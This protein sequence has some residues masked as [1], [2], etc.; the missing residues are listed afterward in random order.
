MW[1]DLDQQA[2]GSNCYCAAAQHFYEV[3]TSAPLAG[4]DNDWEMRFIF[5][6]CDSRQI[7]CVTC[8][9]F[10]SPNAA[11]AQQNVWIALR[12]NIFGGQE[13]FFDPFAH[14]ALQQDWFSASGTFDQELEILGIS[15]AYL[16]KICRIADVLDIPLAQHLRD[17]LQPGF[18]LRELE[19][20]QP[21]ATQALKF[22]G[23]SS[24]FV[25]ASPQNSCAFGFHGSC[26]VHELF[27]G[28]D[29]ARACH[30][31]KVVPSDQHSVDV[32]DGILGLGFPAD[33]FV[34]L[35]D[36]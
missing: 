20:P 14:T 35:L 24:W 32:Y 10:K 34:A 8:V 33:E 4:I 23:R 29:A 7:Q 17:D 27:F 15:S 30:H 22:V 13:P 6:N 11:L 16:Q 28:F 2:V 1:M 25:S 19:Q 12:K 9:S 5:G 31:D 21:L 3:G 36:G 18:F 26:G